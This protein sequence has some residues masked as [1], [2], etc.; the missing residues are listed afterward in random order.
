[1]QKEI[2]NDLI[3]ELVLNVFPKSY[4][5]YIQVPI[6]QNSL[7]DLPWNNQHANFFMK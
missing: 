5:H 3:V 2:E 1:L 4:K 7:P 6:A